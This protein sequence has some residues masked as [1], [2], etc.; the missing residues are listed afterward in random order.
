MLDIAKTILISPTRLINITNIGRLVAFFLHKLTAMLKYL[1][2]KISII[3][4]LSYTYL[5][6]KMTLY[7][8]HSVITK[9]VIFVVQKRNRN[10]DNTK[11]IG[12]RLKNNEHRNTIRRNVIARESCCN[13]C[14]IQFSSKLQLSRRDQYHCHLSNFDKKL[15]SNAK[16]TYNM[17]KISFN[18]AGISNVTELYANG[19]AN[20]DPNAQIWTCEIRNRNI[21]NMKK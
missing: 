10:F 14:N 9:K 17:N 1:Y 4:T 18:T 16:M 15:V 11:S 5:F 21:A 7:I 12:K 3:K 20:Y 6:T 8:S 13:S 2:A 19:N